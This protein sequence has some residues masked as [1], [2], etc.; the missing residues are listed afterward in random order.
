MKLAEN[1]RAYRR[2]RSLTQE[3]LAEV[4]D[5]TGGAVYKWEAGLSQPELRTLMEMA[6]FF[7]ISVD[8][9]L[10]YEVKDNRLSATVERLKR[11]RYTKD[12]AGFAEAEKALKKY[13]NAFAVAYN[14][15]EN[16][17]IMASAP[18]KVT[19]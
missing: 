4:L 8:A 13:P 9:L 5:V 11:C 1:I 15:G 17:S 2:A 19:A 14:S 18:K 12:D 6:D 7:D 10:G 16:Q 3:Q